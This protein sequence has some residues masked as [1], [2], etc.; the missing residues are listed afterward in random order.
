MGLYLAGLVTISSSQD[1]S[2]ISSKVLESS[3]CE[4]TKYRHIIYSSRTGDE[5][6]PQCGPSDPIILV[7]GEIRI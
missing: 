4:N 5:I 3:A 6:Y 7:V 2:E 1:H